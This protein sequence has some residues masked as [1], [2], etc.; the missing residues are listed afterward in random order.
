MNFQN[1]NLSRDIDKAH[2]LFLDRH[3]GNND[4]TVYSIDRLTVLKITCSALY[5]G[6]S[7]VIFTINM[8]VM[9]IK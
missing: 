5:L 8:E 1:I 6:F 7:I 3:E 2:I 9:S 4:L